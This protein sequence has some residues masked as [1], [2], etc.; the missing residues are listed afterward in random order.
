M[1][2]KSSIWNETQELSSL[3]AGIGQVNPYQ[4]PE[5]Y[6]EGLSA[7][8][9]AKIQDVSA[10]GAALPTSEN[11]Y[12]VPAG[13]FEG[14][15]GQVMSRIKLKQDTSEVQT[16]LKELSPLLS[17]ISRLNPYA[18]PGGYFEHLSEELPAIIAEADPA[19]VWM[20]DLKDKSTYQVP[21]DYFVSFPNSVLNKTRQRK[22]APVI[23]MGRSRSWFRY[24]A[25][26]VI[27][28]VVATTGFLIFNR[29]SSGTID[30]AKI[31]SQ[32]KD[33]LQT[34]TEKD[35]SDFLD[36]QDVA[37][38]DNGNASTQTELNSMDASDLLSDIPDDA[39]QQYIDENGIQKDAQAN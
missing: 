28:G 14:F 36:N 38:L 26:A 15:A 6:F 1:T 13:F 27:I 9:L 16:E 29:H 23:S 37:S 17:S 21:A 8:I 4:V 24:A 32:V 3:V 33:S 22:Q 19:P 10:P 2:N 39:L 12:Q 25:A 30:L 31:E 7:S 5:G 18:V 34:A 35:I 20:N 11:P